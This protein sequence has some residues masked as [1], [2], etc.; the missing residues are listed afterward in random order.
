MKKIALEGIDGAGKT[1]VAN[2]LKESFENQGLSVAQFAPF[3]L[4][5][6]TYG[7]DI[8]PLWKSRAGAEKAT[9]LIKAALDHCE[10]EAV[11]TNADVIVYDRHWM[12]VMTEI[13]GRHDLVQKWDRFVPTAVLRVHP[14]VA[15]SRLAAGPKESFTSGPMLQRYADSY[16]KLS[17]RYFSHLLGIYRS[18]EDVT[19][20]ALARNIEW[21]MN[22]RR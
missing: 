21:D 13:D 11:D 2:L 7:S 15:R 10:A 8:Y 16:Q 14:D 18:D 20:A 5:N 3:R 17:S 6:A 22:I 9:M 4:A 12:T 1:T 19:P